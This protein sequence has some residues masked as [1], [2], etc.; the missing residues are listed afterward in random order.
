MRL[1]HKHSLIDNPVVVV[2]ST[3][4]VANFSLLRGENCLTFSTTWRQG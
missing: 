4:M 2:F 3:S 1:A